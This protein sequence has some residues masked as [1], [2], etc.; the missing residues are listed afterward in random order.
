MTRKTRSFYRTSALAGWLIAAILSAPAI[1]DEGMWTVHDFPSDGVYERY[2][3]EVGEDWLNRVQKST[4][5]LDGGCTGSFASAD[6]LVL[7]NNHCVWGCVRNLSSDEENLSETGFLAAERGEERQCPG[8]RISVL[9]DYEN[10][11]EKVHAVAMGKSEAVANQDRK[12]LLSR[13]EKECE[14]EGELSCESVSLYHGG[15]Y[16]LYKYRRYDDV[17][18]VFAPELPI[19]A[20][21][22]D[23]DNFN[24][25]RWNLDMS[26]LRVYEDGKPAQTPEFLPWRQ[27]GAQE[28]E[29]VFVS[30]HPGNTD[31]LLTVAELEERRNHYLPDRLIFYSE[32]R[33]RMIEW[34][35]SG[36]EAARQVQQRILGYENGIKVWRNQLKS[37][38]D[39]DQMARKT[40]A[41]TDLREAVMADPE[42]AEAYGGAWDTVERALGAWSVIS[43][44]YRFIES[45][46]G[47]MGSLFGWGR[48]LVRGTGEREKPN[49][50]RLRAYRDTAL[51]RVE[52]RLL[53]ATPVNSGFETL[54]LAFSLDKLRETLGPDHEVVRNVLAKE[55]P[56][57]LAE[58][59]VTNSR[60]SDPAYRKEL[61]EGGV[62]AVAAS[63]DPV[64][65][66]I[67]N[68]EQKARALRKRYED[69]VEAP[70]A[71]ASEQIA[72][73]RFAILG[74][75]VYP[76]ATFTLRV[77]YGA[78]EGWVEKGEPVYP[79][80]TLERTYG[81][82]TGEDPFRL[83][84]S[85]L[86]ARE[87]LDLDTR[88]NFVSTTDIIGGN[89]GSP[90]INGAGEL[91]GLAF[92]GNIH[93]IAGGYWFDERVNRT[94]SV[95]VDAMLEALEVIYGADT[96]LGELNIQR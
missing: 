34:A 43:D 27:G 47:F 39:A 40:Q 65:V 73:A 9:H 86:D 91:V 5:R 71:Q 37:L 50:E 13:L 55:S 51:P 94:V 41:E 87:R 2:S 54:G 68:I 59:L 83:P 62:K 74:K 53:S 67:R 1:A 14:N 3:V 22:G 42:L 30:G 25:P 7:T 15:E 77:T 19:A 70:L 21:G 96:L 46:R 93:S 69:E 66:L 80:T 60:L 8:A 32:F 44:E 88:Y 26:F 52:Q 76:D 38:A 20:F 10:V 36:D 12:A 33:G 57:A 56:R 85:W 63:D 48:T 58:R 84:D 78:V 82:A 72:K 31:R 61:W 45:R 35:R 81:R 24:F 49:D 6:G 79:F 17:R 28:N 16:Y 4:V 92:D 64:I 89:S 23:P 75:K 90:V 11:T 29:A 95:H 18:L